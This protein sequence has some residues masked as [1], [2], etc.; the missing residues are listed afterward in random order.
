MRSI[1]FLD[2]A[3]IAKGLTIDAYR[4]SHIVF[5]IR[6][7]ANIVLRVGFHL[8]VGLAVRSRVLG[9][10][11]LGVRMN[12]FD[13][14]LALFHHLSSAFPTVSVLWMLLSTVPK[15]KGSA[16]VL[17]CVPLVLSLR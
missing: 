15:A 8:D 2:R 9:K 1:S 17:L 16:V 12:D 14:K 5:G 13:R 10:C 4:G 6:L 11:G 3:V 7:D